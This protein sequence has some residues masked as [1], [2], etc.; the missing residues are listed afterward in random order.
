MIPLQVI[1]ETRLGVG[2]EW[3]YSNL[4]LDDEAGA[5]SG[6]CNG[7]HRGCKDGWW[8]TVGHY[9]AIYGKLGGEGVL[10]IAFNAGDC[11]EGS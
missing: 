9:S 4:V 1:R 3:K 8:N 5:N 10:T 7:P 11:R 6:R 2:R